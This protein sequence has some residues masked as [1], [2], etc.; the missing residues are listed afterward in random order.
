MRCLPISIL[1]LWFYQNCVKQQRT[2]CKDK[3]L[4]YCTLLFAEKTIQDR[5]DL[6][7]KGMCGYNRRMNVEQKITQFR[8]KTILRACLNV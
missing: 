7:R 2:M 5:K 6:K 3:R 4:E 8:R 1:L